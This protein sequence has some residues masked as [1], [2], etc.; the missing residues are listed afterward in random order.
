MLTYQ[1]I[2]N[3]IIESK[4][5]FLKIKFPK[6][7]KYHHDKYKINKT[8]LHK[9]HLFR[10]NYFAKNLIDLLHI[11]CNNDKLCY[12]SN[13]GTISDVSDIDITINNKKLDKFENIIDI[14]KKYSNYFRNNL[15]I[16][17]YFDMNFYY[18]SLNCV[19]KKKIILIKDCKKL[20]PLSLNIMKNQLAWSCYRIFKS[21]ET[22]L[23]K[24]IQK[25]FKIKENKTKKYDIKLLIKMQ[26]KYINNYKLNSSDK[27][28]YNYY[29]IYSL[30]K[31]NEIDAYYSIGAYVHIV[32]IIQINLVNPEIKNLMF[33][34]N[35]KTLKQLFIL[36][37]FDNLGFFIEVNDN[38]KLKSILIDKTD[39]KYLYRCL[40]AYYLIKLLNNK[41]KINKKILYE[42]D[43]ELFNKNN[44]ISGII[45]LVNNKIKSKISDKYKINNNITKEESLQIMEQIIEELTIVED[46]K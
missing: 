22:E 15:N 18:D 12:I 29:N 30:L 13:V 20:K 1:E 34:Y 44:N 45:N 17:N 33:N 8:L 46:L 4:K 6:R 14:I 36:S 3:N 31:Y 41:N 25:K 40:N 11:I 28:R 32:E 35:K 43:D 27:N 10:I 19:N 23:T 9:I 21:N 24:K 2:Y 39:A 16:A 7:F 37:F 38:I 26:N 42:I 5:I